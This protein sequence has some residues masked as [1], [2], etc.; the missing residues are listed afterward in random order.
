MRG[1]EERSKRKYRENK[2]STVAGPRPQAAH[3]PS[4]AAASLALPRP[5]R[6]GE[7]APPLVDRVPLQH[8]PVIGRR[9]DLYGLPGGLV[10]Q[11]PPVDERGAERERAGARAGIGPPRVLGAAG[12]GRGRRGRRRRE[13]GARKRGGPLLRLLSLS[14]PAPRLLLLLRRPELARRRR[15]PPLV[16]A[17]FSFS[18]IFSLFFS[19]YFFLF[20]RARERDRRG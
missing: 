18:F 8:E 10:Q 5:R 14:L 20:V 6:R 12:R 9:S 4:A 19:L 2:N 3:A 17:L 15:P 13:E 16:G 1:A 7:R 11:E